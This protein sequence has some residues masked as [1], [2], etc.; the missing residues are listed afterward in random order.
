MKGSW[1][2]VRHLSDIASALL[3]VHAAIVR[4]AVSVARAARDGEREEVGLPQRK[5]QQRVTMGAHGRARA[6]PAQPEGWVRIVYEQPRL[7]N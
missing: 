7:D 5:A 1:Q 4:C 6:A 2:L 3:E